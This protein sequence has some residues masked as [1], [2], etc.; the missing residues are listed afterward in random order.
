MVETM[1]VPVASCFQTKTHH[2]DF[3]LV[4]SGLMSMVV[5]Q[6]RCLWITG[7]GEI[8]SQLNQIMLRC[9]AC[10]LLVPF[11]CSPEL[12]TEPG[13][14][15]AESKQESK[16]KASRRLSLEANSLRTITHLGFE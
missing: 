14:A 4:C 15:Q 10:L 3:G 13:E 9:A 8:V 12:R 16:Q 1:A 7:K 6:F 2:L 5:Q 11:G